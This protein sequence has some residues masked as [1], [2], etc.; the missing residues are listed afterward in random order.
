MKPTKKQEAVKAME[1]FSE[2]MLKIKNIHYANNQGM[3][4]ELW[5]NSLEQTR[6]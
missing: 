2:W 5:A 6:Y 3:S 4:N 1:K